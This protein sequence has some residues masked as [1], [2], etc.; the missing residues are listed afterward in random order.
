MR[1]CLN[2]FFP[3]G[4][5]LSPIINGLLP[6]LTSFEFELICVRPLYV[7]L[8]TGLSLI[9]ELSNSIYLGVVPQHPP[10]TLTPFETILATLLAKSS[11]VTSY[12]VFP[13]TLFGIPALGMNITG[14]D[15]TSNNFSITSSKSFGPKEQFAPIPSTPNPSSIQAIEYGVAPVISLLSSLYA[16]VTKT[17]NELFSLTARTADLVS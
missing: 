17:G 5:I 3:V 7:T 16:F 1:A 14:R 15:E 8:L 4:L 6:N 9:N 10:A 11:A 2:L 13:S 12:T